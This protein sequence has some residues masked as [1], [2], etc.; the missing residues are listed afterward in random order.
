ML[1]RIY[2]GVKDAQVVPNSTLNGLSKKYLTLNPGVT[3]SVADITW[4]RALVRVTMSTLDE[5]ALV[6][7]GVW[8]TSEPLSNTVSTVM[9]VTDKRSVVME[10]MLYK[11]QSLYMT[12]YPNVSLCVETLYEES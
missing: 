4:P 11:G 5:H 1:A 6:K 12:A 2:T 7:Y 3:V 9:E 10:E 8:L